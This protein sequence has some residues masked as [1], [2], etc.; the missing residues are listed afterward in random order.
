VDSKFGSSWDKRCSL[1]S[2]GAFGV[3]LWKNIRKGWRKF[4]CHT[5]FEVGDGSKINFLNDQWCG[6]V[7]LNEAFLILFGIAHEKDASVATY[8]EFYGGSN[9]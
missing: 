1:Q 6:D 5:R 4:L 9:Q 7:A 3:E 8:S 2:S